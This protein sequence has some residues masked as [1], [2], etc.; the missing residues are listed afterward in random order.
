MY[1]VDLYTDGSCEPISGVGGWAFILRSAKSGHEIQVCG[2]CEETTNN[3]ME[4]TAV[5]EGLKA[6]TSRCE[7]FIHADSK[8]VLDGL[9]TWLNSWKKNNWQKSDKKPVKN[10]DLWLI[11]DDLKSRH[12]LRYNWIKGHNDH[13]ENEQVDKMAV[14]IRSIS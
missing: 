12:V 1:K 10:K 13:E 14:N 9:Q 8:Y 7:V 4:M 6:L 11:L 3:R 5:I 2:K